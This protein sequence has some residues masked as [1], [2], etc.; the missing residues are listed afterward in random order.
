MLKITHQQSPEP[1]KHKVGDVV[2][3]DDSYYMVV[4]VNQKYALMC[5]PSL[6]VWDSLSYDSLEELW[7]N[8]KND[9][10]LDAELIIK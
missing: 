10:F 1:R 7:E 4:K 3:E 6:Y 5:L 2:K 8:N 9:I